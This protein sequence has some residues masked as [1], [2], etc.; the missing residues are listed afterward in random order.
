[1]KGFEDGAKVEYEG[2]TKTA[3]M[4]TWIKQ[5]SV[6]LVGIL[7][8]DNQ[9]VYQKRGVPLVKLFAES[10]RQLEGAGCSDTTLCSR[11]P[12]SSVVT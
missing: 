10:V 6:P 11:I 5:N 2:S 9:D 4:A 12:R 3:E 1:M 8:E 7:T